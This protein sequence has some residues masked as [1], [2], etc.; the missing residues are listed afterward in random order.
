MIDSYPPPAAEAMALR[1]KE[2]ER[3]PTGSRRYKKSRS[4]GVWIADD[5]C[6]AGVTDRSKRAD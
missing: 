2:K 6:S 3:M 4:V 5:C 1:K